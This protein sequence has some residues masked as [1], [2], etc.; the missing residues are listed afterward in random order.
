[1]IPAQDLLGRRCRITKAHGDDYLY[2]AVA[3]WIQ[4]QGGEPG[5]LDALRCALLS[6]L[7]QT[8]V[9]HFM[10]LEF[11]PAKEES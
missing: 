6:D 2:T 11:E 4:G 7:G 5:K 1:M 9:T 8:N 10:E 3:V